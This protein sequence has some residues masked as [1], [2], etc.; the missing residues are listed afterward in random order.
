M[1]R[2]KYET[3]MEAQI[4]GRHA[5]NLPILETLRPLPESSG[6]GNGELRST[7]G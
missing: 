3:A 5:A 2:Q 6:H 1:S 4:D 7:T